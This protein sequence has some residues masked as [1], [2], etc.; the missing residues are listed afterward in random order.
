[1]SSVLVS[2]LY[3]NINRSV[4]KIKDIISFISSYVLDTSYFDT[5]SKHQIEDCGSYI[6]RV[7]GEL[8]SIAGELFRY[9]E[10][11][12]KFNGVVEHNIPELRDNVIKTLRSI[13]DMDVF[14]NTTCYSN[15]RDTV[16]TYRSLF[17]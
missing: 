12:K 2:F 1:M 8:D 4:Y 17:D 11:L 7:T 10:E 5:S 13:Q 6:N 9:L 15:I 16:D 14:K 3:K